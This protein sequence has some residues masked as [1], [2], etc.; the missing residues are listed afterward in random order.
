MGTSLSWIAVAGKEAPKVLSQLELVDTGR[1]AGSGGAAIIGGVLPGGSY[2]VVFNEF[3]HP[4]IQPDWVAGLSSDCLV[5]GCSEEGNVNVSL[6]FAWRYC[7]QAWH[8]SHQLDEGRDHFDTDGKLPAS[9]ARFLREAREAARVQNHDVLFGVPGAI[10]SDLSGFDPD[11]LGALQLNELEI[12]PRLPY[13]QAVDAVCAAVERL[14]A[15]LGFTVESR[16][17]ECVNYVAN[18]GQDRIA[19]RFNWTQMAK[20][21]C[22]TSMFFDALD[23]RV[24]GLERSALPHRQAPDSTY[25]R[26]F[27]IDPAVTQGS[28]KTANDLVAWMKFMETEL[29]RHI[30]RIRDIE[31]L[32]AL[33]NDGSPRKNFM[34]GPT[35]SHYDHNTGFARLVLA[36]LVR[37]PKLDQMVAETDAACGG[38]PS[39]DNDVHKLM[40]Y[41]RTKVI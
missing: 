16:H 23:S 37:N 30:G 26:H 24:L 33:V 17:P 8:V 4:R 14:M 20:R 1:S 41:L 21:Y 32:E 35:K 6:A 19:C 31:G 38:G 15:G 34:G 29:P 7:E 2:V 5:V 39:P 22:Y 9:A 40:A 36:Y 28:I 10:A 11:A 27:P 13:S 25:Y 18:R 12:A 3:W